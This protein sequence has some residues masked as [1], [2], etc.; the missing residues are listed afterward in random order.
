[1]SLKFKKWIFPFAI[2]A[3]SFG[4]TLQ[5]SQAFADELNLYGYLS[6][7]I[8]KVWDELNIDE[9]GNTVKID[10]PRE[11]ALPSFN[12]MMLHNISEKVKFFANLNGAN[13]EDIT[14][15]NAWAEYKVSDALNIRLGKTY[16]QFG[17]Y[18]EMLDAVPT[19][20]G[21][22]PPELFDQDHLIL[23]RETLLMVHGWVPFGD[24]ELRYSFST[25]NGEGGPSE[26]DNIPLGFDLRYD[27][28]LAGYLIGVSGYTSNGDTVSDVALGEGSPRTG[29][30]PWMAQDDFSVI[31]LYGQYEINSFKFQAAY[32]SS[33]HD[34]TRDAEAVL[35]VIDNADINNAQRA[36]FLKD[37]NAAATTDNVNLDGDY[38]VSTWYIRAGYSFYLNSGAE[39]LPYLQWD[40][41]E[42]PETIRNKTYG[43]DNEVGLTDDG[44]FTKSTI[45]IIYRP[46]PQVA[47]KFDTSTHFQKFNGKNES[48]SEI[49][50]DASYIF[51]Q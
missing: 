24:G 10:A 35:T 37:P 17:L 31:G 38:D 43:G 27:A 28:S 34:A 40:S 21:I 49:R 41:Y 32:W 23:S 33:S 46:I 36:R 22:E 51:G 9:N 3:P 26:D 47:F 44:V 39:V 25:D 1:M 4:A 6:W 14:V 5:P 30:L 16:R 19:Y 11:I 15:S 50:F 29:V 7:R 42:N 48:F 45:G 8:E 13:A 20:I 18:N 2:L 12:I